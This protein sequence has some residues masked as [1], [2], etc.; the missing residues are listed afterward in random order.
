ME[1][2]TNERI[3]V[4][5]ADR[6][7]LFLQSL[8]L[9]IESIAPDME[10]SAVASSGSEIIRTLGETRAN[11]AVIGSHLP[12][13]DISSVIHLIHTDYPRTDIILLL[14]DKDI[15]A[16]PRAV[17]SEVS[18]YL[19]K[20]ASPRILLAAIR[21]VSEGLMLF[22]PDIGVS[23]IQKRLHEGC[24]IPE[25]PEEAL[26][27][28]YY[29]LNKRERTVI[30]RMLLGKTNREIASE[31]CICEQ[32]VRNYISSIYT[33]LEVRDRRSALRKLCLIPPSFFF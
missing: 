17:C 2:R 11:I 26:P 23:L 29:E 3:M 16:V 12:D 33:K 9:L 8:R 30:S 22:D 5:L 19:S 32:T 4:L 20:T 14:E 7:Y 31:I 6:Q 25:F 15:P 21:A 1:Y 13:M 27:F 18:G 28:W 24:S 10:V